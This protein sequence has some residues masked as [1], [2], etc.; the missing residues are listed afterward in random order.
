MDRRPLRVM[1]VTLLA[2]TALTGAAWATEPAPSLTEG[3]EAPDFTLKDSDSAEVTLS[4][5]RGRAVVI[6]DFGRFTCKPC[7]TTA[8]ELQKLHEAYKDAGLRV[9]QVNLDGSKAEEV[10]PKAREELGVTFPV[11]LDTDGRVAGLYGVEVIPFLVVVDRDGIVRHVQTGIEDDTP[12]RLAEIYEQ[13]KPLV[14]EGM[15]APDFTLEDLAGR[16]YKLSDYRDDAV[17]VLDF[18]RFSCIPCRKTAQA[19]QRLSED[20]DGAG[21]LRIFQVNLD[22]PEADTVVPK[23]VKDLGVMFPILLDRDYKVADA[24]G[25]EVIPF[26]LVI[27]PTG[28]VR[29]M[30]V[31]YEEDLAETIAKLHDEY[32]PS[33]PT[34]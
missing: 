33:E 6:L 1:L 19:L 30:H 14:A 28:V 15:E 3:V 11:L 20:G 10:V 16:A 18:G 13:Y 24:Y 26:V 23:G 8:Q 27:D 17:V 7:R 34:P 5:F 12:A 29:Y 22:G 4:D 31:G 2:F 32:R 9:F 25:V 21:S